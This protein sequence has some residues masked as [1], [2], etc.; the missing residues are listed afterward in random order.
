MTVNRAAKIIAMAFLLAGATAPA[1]A[2]LLLDAGVQ[3]ESSGTPIDVPGYSVP[4]TADWDSDGLYDLIVG[5][6]S[7]TG[8]VRVYLNVGTASQ[9]EFTGFTYA[10]SMGADLA[11][12][13]GG[14]LG[15]FPRVVYWDADG[16]K[17]LVV[18]RSDG[19]VM[20]FTNTGTDESPEFDAGVILQFGL[21]GFQSDIDVGSR[22]CPTVVD[23]DS[24]GRR[25][26]V[27]GAYD[28]RVYIFR[29]A[30]VDTVPHYETVALAQ[31]GG[32]DLDVISNRSSPHVEDLDGDGKKDLLSG[33]T[34]GE[35][36]FYA[37]TAFDY[38][39]AFSG[40]E[41]VEADSVK[42]DLSGTPRSR[43]FVCDWND[44]GERD[45]LVGAGDGAVHLYLGI[46][47]GSG[48]DDGENPVQPEPL[49][50][51]H[52]PR[53]NPATPASV[54]AFELAAPSRVSLALYDAVGRCVA[55][56][57]QGRLEAG[58]HEVA[59]GELLTGGTVRASGVY[60]MSLKAGDRV[61]TR[62]LVLVR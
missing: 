1:S 15:I 52:A 29:N 32:A 61:A 50:L 3:V 12:T 23:W 37:N 22:A 47:Q 6:G 45:L 59:V 8:K 57:P 9:P 2:N 49:V 56:L 10:Q 26:L 34:N 40:Y 19:R 54:V 14:C 18:G 17:D 27:V 5:E 13:G 7:S 4:S 16:L 39:P 58:P 30:G 31:D 35:I 60:F 53:P 44:D 42:I 21:A 55:T 28:G 36:V 62:K 46:E 51:L 11:V 41:F 20:L 48:V 24:D 25:D 38:A 33:N 43:P